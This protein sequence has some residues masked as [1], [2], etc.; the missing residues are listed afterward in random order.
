VSQ[1][2]VEK[3]GK[4]YARNPV[5]TGPFIFESWTREQVVVVGNKDFQQR[6]G[7]PKI[8]KVIYKTIPDVDT[9]LLALQ[10]GDIDIVWV[11]PRDSAILDRLV[12][13]G[14]KITYTKR[15][16]FQVLFMN[17]KNRPFDDV[18]VRRA[19]AHAIDKD[20]LV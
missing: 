14:C 17:N 11:L 12:A 7:P 18:R 8:D 5:G 9:Q 13:S 3:F 20:A 6:E 1:K 2:A 4:D 19:V 10:R 16:T 15:P